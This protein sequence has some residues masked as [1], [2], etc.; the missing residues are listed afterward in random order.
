MSTYSFD[1]AGRLVEAVIPHHT[2]SY[3]YGPASCGVADAGKNGNRTTF[4]DDFDGLVSSVGYCYDTADRL[5]GTS[6]TNAPV[7]APALHG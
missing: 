5:T 6:V 3:G 2:L 7:G 1:A 4:T